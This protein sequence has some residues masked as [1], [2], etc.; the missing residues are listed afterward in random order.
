MNRCAVRQRLVCL[1]L[2][3]LGAGVATAA[4]DLQRDKF[5]AIIRGDVNSKRMALVF[6]GDE[7]GEGALAI[8]DALKE[9]G[10]R[11][12]FFLTGNYLRNATFRPHVARMVAEGHYVGPH[13]D[14]HLLY[15]PWDAREKSLVTQDAFAADL[16]KNLADLRALGAAPVGAAAFFI[17]PYEWYNSD[18]VRWSHKL[19][20]QVV[21]LTPGPRSQRDY[22]R[23]GDKAFVP[24][25][26][27]YDEIFK[28]A[29]ERPEGLNGVLLLL[30]LG[31]GRKDPFH[32]LVG[33]LCDEL[34]RRGYQLVG[35][36]QLC[37][38]VTEQ[39]PRDARV[40]P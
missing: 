27:I 7:F 20:V 3:G 25:Q 12:S 26:Q 34:S 1:A 39:V 21:N 14:G 32:P 11:A 6:T 19:G 2:L 13:S 10:L 33:R 29:D 4:D 8:L 22:A 30:H 17:P 31:S 28:Y 18:Q 9:R 23:E 38:A 36:D 35:V 40:R 16:K 15:A 37:A 5:G 24:S